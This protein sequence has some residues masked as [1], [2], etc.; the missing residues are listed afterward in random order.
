[1]SHPFRFA[2]PALLLICCL[3]AWARQ[4]SGQKKTITI[5]EAADNALKQSQL[6]RPGSQAFHL[7]AQ[8]VNTARRS[9]QYKAEVEEYWLSPQ[10]W[11]RRIASPEFSQTL[12]VDGDKVSEHDKGNYYPFWLRNLVTAMFD[13]LPMREQLMHFKGELEVPTDSAQSNSCLEFSAPSGIPPLR[14]SVPY[15]FCFQGK[16]GLLQRVV[17]PGYTAQFQDYRPFQ[18]RMV[19]R[20]ITADLAPDVILEATITE[21]DDAIPADRALFTVE[22]PTPPAEQLKSTQ[23]GEAVARNLAMAAPRIAWPA[24]REGKSSGMITLYISVDKLGQVREVRTLASD[25]PELNAAACEQVQHWRF[26]PYVNGVPLQMESELTFAFDTMMGEPI[27]LLSNAAARK[28]AIHVVE[29]K[30]P[31]AKA[32]KGTN[33]TVRIRVDEQ[34][35]LVRVENLKGANPAQAAAAERALKQWR[36]RPYLRNGKPD[37]FDADIVFTLPQP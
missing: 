36:F 17:T 30:I 19:A 25:N 3:V 14:G 15:V 2:R 21:L 27:P 13:S 7:K 32:L 12:V 4:S 16:R 18:G 6:T 8:I 34:G 22:Q 24:V 1:M 29:P 20:R 23:L 10:S 9:S 5:G 37:L 35:R 33:V 26:Q 31:S 28:L 11:R